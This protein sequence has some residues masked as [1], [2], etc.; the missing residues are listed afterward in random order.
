MRPFR[1]PSRLRQSIQGY[2]SPVPLR[3][4]VQDGTEWHKSPRESTPLQENY[5]THNSHLCYTLPERE[6]TGAVATAYRAPNPLPDPT[7][8]PCI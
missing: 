8:E 5:A 2:A 4:A 1:N 7:K 3:E 6:P